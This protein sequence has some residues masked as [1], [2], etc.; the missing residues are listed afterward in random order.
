MKNSINLER[1]EEDM[2]VCGVSLNC[3]VVCCP[4]FLTAAF[5]VLVDFFVMERIDEF[6]P[7]L[8]VPTREQS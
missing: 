3:E 8:G 7:I 5:L 2:L 1:R 6:M 4:A